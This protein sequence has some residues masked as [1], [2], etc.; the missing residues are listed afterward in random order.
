MFDISNNVLYDYYL[1]PDETEVVIP[2]GVTLIG[3]YAFEKCNSL[4][5]VTIPDSVT[6][7]LD[8]AFEGCPL[9]EFHILGEK[10]KLLIGEALGYEMPDGLRDSMVELLPYMDDCCLDS[11]VL[12]KIDSC[13][14]A[15][16]N[17]IANEML[18]QIRRNPNAKYCRT[19]ANYGRNGDDAYRKKRGYSEKTAK[20]LRMIDG[21]SL[22][23]A[24][25]E[26]SYE[27]LGGVNGG[28]R[29]CL[30]YPICRY[31]DEDTLSQI[32][33]RAH[34]WTSSRLGNYAPAIREFRHGCM[35]S[36][37]YSAVAFIKRHGSSADLERYASMR[38]IDVLTLCDMAF[39]SEE[40]LNVERDCNSRLFRRFLDGILMPAAIW[41]KRRSFSPILCCQSRQVVWV[42]GGKTFIMEKDGDG[43]IDSFGK[44]YALTQEDVK[45][46]YPMEMGMEELT[47]WHEY[48]TSNGIKQPFPQIWLPNQ[49]SGIVKPDHHVRLPKQY[50]VSLHKKAQELIR[51]DD[52]SVT[53]FVQYFTNSMASKY[54]KLAQ[55]V[56][57]TNALAA[58]LD[59][60][61]KS[62]DDY[63]LMGESEPS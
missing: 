17:K 54:V 57:S 49:S 38:G 44:P 27:Y 51:E 26:L 47:R 1:E 9:E 36:D 6:K 60:L 59:Y 20:V 15:L 12:S 8:W 33:D 34:N 41:D 45:I 62:Q 4:K 2:E 58:L 39:S 63:D 19:V 53:M 14:D 31:A 5:S 52:T 16:L 24:L 55:D 23:D 22:Q 37:T 35:V 25:L 50:Y 42:Q 48:L 30:A 11:Y 21:E 13:D 18:G 40:G 29:H 32:C 46:A 7:I 61:D 43:V 3:T 56:N 28:L 10:R